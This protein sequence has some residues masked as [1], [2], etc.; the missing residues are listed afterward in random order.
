MVNAN[1]T[2]TEKTAN[3]FSKEQLVRSKRF[4]GSQDLLEAALSSDRKY[5]I[6]E[7]DGIIS[8]YKKGRVK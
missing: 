3:V 2:T 4:S 7:A 1:K 8:S 5:T 6:D